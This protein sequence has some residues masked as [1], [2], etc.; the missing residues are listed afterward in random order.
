MAYQFQF[1][2]EKFTFTNRSFRQRSLMVR[3]W[4]SFWV[5]LQL[6]LIG[7]NFFSR[8]SLSAFQLSAFKVGSCFESF[9]R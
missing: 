8:L 5:R 9:Q 2:R 4:H 6:A 3:N 1:R 7:A